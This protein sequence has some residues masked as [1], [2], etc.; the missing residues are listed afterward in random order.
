V[1][2]YHV[3]KSARCNALGSLL[4]DRFHFKYLVFKFAA[5]DCPSNNIKT[6]GPTEHT[7]NGTSLIARLQLFK[8]PAE[9]VS[10]A[11]PL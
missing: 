8:F 9:L 7:V 3:N 5:F 2:I 4:L 1:D 10:I 11:V 6:G